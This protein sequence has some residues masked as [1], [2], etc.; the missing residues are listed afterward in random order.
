M[1]GVLNTRHN[2]GVASLDPVLLER[3]GRLV[4]AT[5]AKVVLSTSWRL[6]PSLCARIL[7]ALRTYAGVGAE[8]VI[9]KT[10]HL[11]RPPSEEHV[12]GGP[13]LRELE[14]R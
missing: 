3:A 6:I 1:D 5:D 7:D 9:G 2:V 8:T 10:V 13:T 14:I 11:T 4:R 12:S